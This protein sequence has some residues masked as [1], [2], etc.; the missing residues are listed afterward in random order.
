MKT[1]LKFRRLILAGLLLLTCA[2]LPV[3]AALK[4]KAYRRHPTT[5][6][7]RYLL[8]GDWPHVIPFRFLMLR[9]GTPD[10]RESTRVWLY[11]TAWLTDTWW[12][13][14]LLQRDLKSMPAELRRDYFPTYRLV[15]CPRNK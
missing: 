5:A 6:N 3:R 12:N 4:L 11:R 14:K 10:Y 1:L 15:S 7:A 9:G 2:L 8:D 13:R